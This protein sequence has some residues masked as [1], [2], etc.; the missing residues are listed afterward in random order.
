MDIIR[1]IPEMQAWALNAWRAGRRI[2]LVPTMGYLHAG[3]LSLVQVA[4][5]HAEVTV[6][7]IYVNPTQFGPN[8]DLAAYPR[9]FERDEALCRDAG[10]DVVFYPSD[11]DMYAPDHSVW[12]V[13]EVLSKPLC[14]RSRPT[15]FRGVATVVAKLFNAVLPTVAVFGQKDAQQAL[16]IQRLARDLNSPVRVIV[17]PTV[18]EPDGLAMSSRNKYLSPDERQRAVA[19]SKGLRRAA[20]LYAAGTRDVNRLRDTVTDGITAAAGR[21]D[22]VEILSRDAL[23]PVTTV[24]RPCLLAVAAFFGKTRLIDNG[25]LG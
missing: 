17:A 20:D 15:H 22:Y 2:G 24:D 4:R 13:E 6:V 25:F 7:S 18:R 5:V 10:V 16:V 8:E 21:V 1:T 19:I 12:I 23:A 3:H 14:G 11:A 9:D